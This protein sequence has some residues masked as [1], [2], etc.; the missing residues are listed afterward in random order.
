MPVI[1]VCDFYSL[2]EMMRVYVKCN[3]RSHSTVVSLFAV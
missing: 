3:P 2:E 1:G